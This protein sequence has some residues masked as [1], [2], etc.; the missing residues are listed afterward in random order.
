M[1][2]NI[3]FHLAGKKLKEFTTEL[4]F[5]LTQHE[6]LS[7]KNMTYFDASENEKYHPYIIETSCGLNRIFLMVLCD[8]YFE[9]TENE[10][11]IETPF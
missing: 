4:D 9:D 11:S 6:K 2:F 3:N 5:D 10:G 1:I 8:A 7:G